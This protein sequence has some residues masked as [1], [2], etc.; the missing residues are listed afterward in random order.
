MY[1]GKP[2]KLNYVT[3][4][5]VRPP[6]FSVFTNQPE[7]VG[8]SYMRYLQKKLREEY[9]F[10]GTPLVV[11]FRKKR[12]LSEASTLTPEVEGAEGWEE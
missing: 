8:D 5:R 7:G 6:T 3:Q 2:V 11:L 12:R 1:R 10:E 4:V 9:G